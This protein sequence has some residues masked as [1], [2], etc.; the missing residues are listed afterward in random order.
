MYD[1]DSNNYD[2]AE[3][4]SYKY[5]T[6]IPT[7]NYDNLFEFQIDSGGTYLQIVPKCIDMIQQENYCYID[8]TLSSYKFIKNLKILD[9][10]D[11]MQNLEYFKDLSSEELQNHINII[12]GGITKEYYEDEG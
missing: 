5:Y 4:Y 1:A 12:I 8:I 10:G 9:Y 6:L 3:P 11:I 2:N 7:T